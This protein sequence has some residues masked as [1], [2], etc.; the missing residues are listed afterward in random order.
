M[1]IIAAIED[2][3]VIAKI[4]THLGIAHPR[5]PKAPSLPRRILATSLIS[6]RIP[7]QF[8]EPTNPLCPFPPL[9]PRKGATSRPNPRTMGRSDL[10]AR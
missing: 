7:V 4:L 5:P 9:P 6:H 3:P 8:L 1:T 10:L 2:P